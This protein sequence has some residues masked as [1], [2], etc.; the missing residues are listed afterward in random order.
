[1]GTISYFK[2]IIWV[3]LIASSLAGIAAEETMQQPMFIETGVVDGLYIGVTNGKG[4]SHPTVDQNLYYMIWTVTNNGVTVYVPTQSEYAYQ[5]DLVDAKG[6]LIPKTAEG[7]NAGTKFNDLNT[8]F[9]NENA[10]LQRISA[11]KKNQPVEPVHLFYIK[12][13]FNINKPGT[14]ILHVRFQII[15]RTGKGQDRTAH[16]VRFPVLNY[17]VVKVN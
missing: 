11:Y 5:I 16:I 2:L 15:V 1:M 10:K 3:T 14:Y 8:S 9:S 4:S 12:E 13:H 6:V 17:S 7:M